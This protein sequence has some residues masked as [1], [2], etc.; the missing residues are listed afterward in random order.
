M[1]N[2]RPPNSI[3]NPGG[4]MPVGVSDFAKLARGDYCFVDKSLFIKQVLDTGDDVTLITRPRRFGKTINMN[5]LRCFLQE[6]GG[7]RDAIHRVSTGE[8]NKS[9]PWGWRLPVNKSAW[10]RNGFCRKDAS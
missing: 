10:R 3:V 8:K 2:P 5:M 7:C 9:S 4:K 1:S 6:S